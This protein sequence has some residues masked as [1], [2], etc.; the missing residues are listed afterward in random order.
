MRIEPD[1]GYT[2]FQHVKCEHDR[3]HFRISP[4]VFNLPEKANPTRMNLF[5]V[6]TGGL[7]LDHT[8]DR[9]SPLLVRGFS[10]E[11][12]YFRRTAS[13]LKHIYGVHYDYSTGVA[14]HPV[15]HAQMKSFADF[16]EEISERFSCDNAL[17]DRVSNILRNVRLPCAQMDVFSLL[18]QICADH[19]LSENS[20]DE[21]VSLFE[22]M[23]GLSG[24][25]QGAGKDVAH[26]STEAM[27]Q[28][29]RSTHWYPRLTGG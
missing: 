29:V 17:D 8:I 28:C 2:N 6:L 5:V 11:V 4:T 23:V 20:S 24:F 12:G 1:D 21:Q 19:L 26:L 13:Q 27:R 14:G 7:E 3:D 18:L 16:S 15:F 10:S 22:G 25:L 9:T